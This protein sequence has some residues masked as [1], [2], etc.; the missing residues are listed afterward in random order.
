MPTTPDPLRGYSKDKRKSKHAFICDHSLKT[1]HIFSITYSVL[2]FMQVF[3]LSTS[4]LEFES[5]TDVC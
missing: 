1:L 2:P 5:V 3:S 4:F